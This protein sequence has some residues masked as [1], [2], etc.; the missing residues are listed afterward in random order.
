[1]RAL[2]AVTVKRLQCTLQVE[3]PLTPALSPSDGERL[4]YRPGEG[5]CKDF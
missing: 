3:Q 1:M 5:I 2:V 4:A